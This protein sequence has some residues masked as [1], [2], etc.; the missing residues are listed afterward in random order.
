MSMLH[1]FMSVAEWPGT[2]IDEIRQQTRYSASTVTRALQILSTGVRPKPSEV[3]QKPGFGLVSVTLDVENWR[4]KA[5]LLTD[6]GR[7]LLQKIEAL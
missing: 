4:T 2:T 3:K 1:V 7:A 5:V 6:K